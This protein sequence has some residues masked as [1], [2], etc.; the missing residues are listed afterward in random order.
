MDT[1]GLRIE[2]GK[3]RGELVTRLP[4]GYLKWLINEGSDFAAVAQAELDRRGITTPTELEVSIHAIDRASI[5]LRRFWK[6]MRQDGDE[7]LYSWLYR[8][9]SEALKVANG[10]TRVDYAG[11]RFVFHYGECY[12]TLKTVMAGRKARQRTDDEDAAIEE[13]IGRLP[14]RKEECA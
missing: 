10:Q 8:V 7:G 13:W 12:P 6:E 5:R 3:H 9:A 11:M 1:H 2:F 14:Q 4:I